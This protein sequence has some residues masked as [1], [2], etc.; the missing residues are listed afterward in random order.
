LDVQLFITVLYLGDRQDWF[1]IGC[2]SLLD[3]AAITTHFS[4]CPVLLEGLLFVELR[5]MG[6]DGGPV[7]LYPEDFLHEIVHIAYLV[8]F[9]VDHQ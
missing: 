2:L 4:F 6:I 3:G 1:F 9:R 7:D 8:Q 5:Q